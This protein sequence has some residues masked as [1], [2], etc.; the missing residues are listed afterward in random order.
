[1]LS[2]GWYLGYTGYQLSI[3]G[4]GVNVI[5][6]GIM[7]RN[8]DLTLF[9]EVV[10]VLEDQY[11]DSSRLVAKDLLY[12]A[13][14]GMVD[15][16][17]DPYTVFYTPEEN[18]DF[19]D[20]LSGVY[21]GIGAELG[22]K[23]HQLVVVAPLEGSPAEMAGL[24]SG[25][26]LLEVE[27]ES[28]QDWSL[29]KAVTMIRGEKAT[30]VNFLVGR[31]DV[32]NDE[33]EVLNIKVRREEIAL[34]SVN[35]KWENNVA[36]VRL[37]RFGGDIK[38]VWQETVSEIIKENAEGV[39]LDLRGNPGGYLEG[40]LVV[41]AEFFSDGEIA[42]RQEADG[43]KQSLGLDHKGQ[44]T[45]IPVVVLVDGG[46]ASSSEIVAGAIQAR[47]RGTLVGE[48]TF[49]KGTVQEALDLGAGA[50]LHV[51]AAKWLLPDGQS[52]DGDGLAPD[53]IIER[54]EQEVEEGRDSQMEKAIELV[55]S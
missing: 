43:R 50:G 41:G 34:P 1:M 38:K 51:T 40:A 13:I 25:D 7:S 52:I 35:L 14:A 24:R 54:S 5:K 6:Q 4:H 3:R 15:S 48:K 27:G 30:E 36:V 49:G 9:W 29:T 12:G 42:Y 26:M 44:L 19:K 37:Y 53:V 10:Q 8:L 47:D 32:Q 20:S 39:V 17:D 46:S 2:T 18:K 11:Y 31:A 21:E 23:E 28:T 16:L 33:I 55:K 45:E 22:F